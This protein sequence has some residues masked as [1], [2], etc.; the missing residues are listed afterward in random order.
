MTRGSYAG[1]P[2]LAAATGIIT[3]VLF[4]SSLT[5]S[6]SSSPS[7]SADPALEHARQQRDAGR[8]DQAVQAYQRYIANDPGAWQVRAELAQVLVTLRMLDEAEKELQQAIL[9]NREQ[10]VLWARLGQVYL[11]KED[12]EHAELSLVRARELD[13][14]SASV[15]FNL[16]RLFQRQGREDEGLEEYLAFLNLAPDDPRAIRV[17]LRLAIYYDANRQPEKAVEELRKLIEL[18]PQDPRYHQRLGNVFYRKADYDRALESYSKVIELQPDNGDVHYNIAFIYRTKAM[19][20]E[21]ERELLITARLK[22]EA[23]D[24]FYLLGSIQYE[25]EKYEEAGATLERSIALDPEDYQV[26]YIYARTLMKLGRREEARREIELHR[27]LEAK[28]RAEDGG[29]TM[30]GIGEE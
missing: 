22:P 27:Q 30:G 14:D 25:L 21:A 10:A 5:L 29:R 24:V 19:L 12:P 13:P 8:L 7:G 4:A 16:G 11:L 20:A 6:Q 17:R 28:A 26:H 18:R 23:A 15:R 3:I 2:R 1:L 9:T